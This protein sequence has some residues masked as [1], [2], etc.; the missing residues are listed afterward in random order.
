MVPT[1]CRRTTSSTA[2]SSVQSSSSCLTL[3]A[4]QR[5]G[6]RRSLA[7]TLS[8]PKRRCKRGM[9]SDPIWPRAP[10]TRMALSLDVRCN[11]VLPFVNDIQLNA[12]VSAFED[13][14]GALGTLSH[15]DFLALHGLANVVSARVEQHGEI[16]RCLAIGAQ[17]QVPSTSQL[18]LGRAEAGQNP[19]RET[20][21]RRGWGGSC[22]NPEPVGSNSFLCSAPRPRN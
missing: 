6:R 12:T 20:A 10:V 21:V 1:L 9:S 14:H 3:F 22:P 19:P 2:W 8:M 7:M 4:A 18:S 13:P 15:D 5:A 17:A 11:T 16:G